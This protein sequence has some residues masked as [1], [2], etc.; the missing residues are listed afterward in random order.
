MRKLI[1]SVLCTAWA[2]GGGFQP[3]SDDEVARLGLTEGVAGNAAMRVGNC[4]PGVSGACRYE[5]L[6]AVLWLV[7]EANASTL[8]A[9]PEEGCDLALAGV[10]PGSVGATTAEL[11]SGQYGV[12]VPPGLYAPVI[13]QPS[14]CG[15]C[16]S[17]T[18][19]GSTRCSLVAVEPSKVTKLDVVLDRAAQ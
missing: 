11:A 8:K 10:S 14:G 15:S 3:I 12:Q 4:M 18:N 9:S 16:I 2:C 17:L 7:P 13:V 6:E 1:L 5:D 19:Q